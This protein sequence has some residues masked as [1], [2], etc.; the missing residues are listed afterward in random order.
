MIGPNAKGVHIGNYS[1]TPEGGVSILEGI[2]N[3]AAK[4]QKILFSEGCKITETDPT[5]FTFE[6]PKPGDSEKNKKRIKEAVKVAKKAD[7][8]VL[9]LGGNEFTSRETW[10]GH[11]GDRDMHRVVEP[12]TFKIMAGGNSKELIEVTLEAVDTK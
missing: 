9:S 4:G 10:I 8:I 6:E 11:L 1:G 2:K 12:G 3:R 5:V 7:A